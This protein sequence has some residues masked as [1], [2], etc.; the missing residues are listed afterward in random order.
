MRRPVIYLFA[1]LIA[2]SAS[3]AGAQRVQGPTAQNRRQDVRQ[4]RMEQRMGMRQGMG[5]MSGMRN[6]GMGG[7]MMNG[8]GMR[9]EN[10][11]LTGGGDLFLNMRGRLDLDDDQVEKLRD[12]RVGLVRTTGNL[13]TDLRVARL[14]LQNLLDTDDPDMNAIEDAVGDIHDAEAKLETARLRARFDAQDVLTPEQR[15][16]LQAP[17]GRGMM[18]NAPEQEE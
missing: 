5:M 1:L 6:R 2:I 8:G 17:R 3:I 14:E 15:E 9:G 4:P 7:G 10:S 12:I 18:R 11:P 16:L 13:E